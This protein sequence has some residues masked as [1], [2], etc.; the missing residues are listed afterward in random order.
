VIIAFVALAVLIPSVSFALGAVVGHGRG[1]SRALDSAPN[2][3]AE[4]GREAWDYGE[5][6]GMPEHRPTLLW[7]VETYLPA[8]WGRL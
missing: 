7:F 1:R 2:L 5:R 3:V 8:H 4:L 6:V